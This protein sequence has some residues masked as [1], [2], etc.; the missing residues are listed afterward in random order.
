MARMPTHKELDLYNYTDVLTG[1][2]Q[3]ETNDSDIVGRHLEE[4]LADKLDAKL[5]KFEEPD[6][7]ELGVNIKSGGL[8]TPQN[9]IGSISAEKF[10][11]MND[12]SRYEW[13]KSHTEHW[14]YIPRCDEIGLTGGSYNIDMSEGTHGGLLLQQQFEEISNKIDNFILAQDDKNWPTC[15]S[16]DKG[17]WAEYSRESNSWKFRIS[18]R[19]RRKIE[20]RDNMFDNMFDL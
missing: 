19:N 20:S 15:K 3:V 4:V 2:Q 5:D 6:L 12:T 1:K 8:K 18:K 16:D 11:T 14:H 17:M 10:K 7:P 9:T 13:F